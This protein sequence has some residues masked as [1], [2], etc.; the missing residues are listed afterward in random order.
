MISLPQSTNADKQRSEEGGIKRGQKFSS[1]IP[2]SFR[3]LQHR[4][5]LWDRGEDI[6]SL[7]G[8][9]FLAVS[10][11]WGWKVEDVWSLGF[12]KPQT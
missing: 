1:L 3:C 2:L 10:L 8:L 5:M 7:G 9:E 12:K 4:T 11:S 6:V